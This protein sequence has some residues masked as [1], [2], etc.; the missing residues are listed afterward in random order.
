MSVGRTKRPVWELRSLRKEGDRII[1]LFLQAGCDVVQ[2]WAVEVLH[3]ELRAG[4]RHRR[5][6]CDHLSGRAENGWA[7][8]DA[9]AK[10]VKTS[11]DK[12]ARRNLSS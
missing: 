8:A 2:I 5:H 4:H 3:P 7:P 6:S 12:A 11:V 1:L 9:E 10:Q